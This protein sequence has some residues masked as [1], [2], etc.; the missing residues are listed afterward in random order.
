MIKE[1]IKKTETMPNIST[2]G[3][4]AYDFGDKVIVCYSLDNEYGTARPM[5]ETLQ[6][7][8]NA[9][10]EKGVQTPKIEKEIINKI[11]AE[12]RK[13]SQISTNTSLTESLKTIEEYKKT[14]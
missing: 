8:I 3:S 6:P 11:Y 14:I 2:G 13:L 12:L 4:P 7:L 9:K 1:L 5:E 10:N